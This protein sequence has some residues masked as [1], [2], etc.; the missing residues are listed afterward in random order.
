V[1]QCAEV[2]GGTYDCIVNLEDQTVNNFKAFVILLCYLI[3]TVL[4]VP[5]LALC[6]AAGYRDEA[7]HLSDGVLTVLL[8]L[9]GR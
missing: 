1:E 4:A 2:C 8:G 6:S 9:A 7:K 3:A 5:F